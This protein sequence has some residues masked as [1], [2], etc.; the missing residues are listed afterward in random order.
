MDEKIINEASLSQDIESRLKKSGIDIST[1]STNEIRDRNV[2]IDTS[3]INGNDKTFIENL[4]RLCSSILDYDKKIIN[5]PVDGWFQKS[6]DIEK[7]NTPLGAIYRYIKQ[8]PRGFRSNFVGFTFIF[9]NIHGEFFPLY[10]NDYKAAE[11]TTFENL[12]TT[13][14]TSHAIHNLTGIGNKKSPVKDVKPA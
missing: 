8:N 2:I 13:L 12:L 3:Y 11:F 1:D 7:G 6:K 10:V 5:I 4:I 9:Y 14:T